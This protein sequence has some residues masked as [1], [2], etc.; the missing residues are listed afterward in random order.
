M[1]QPLW[2]RF[3]CVGRRLVLVVLGVFNA[4]SAVLTTLAETPTVP[5]PFAGH[6]RVLHRP[7]TP[8]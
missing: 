3:R 5:W 4:G 1:L 8:P 7:V 2:A 6:G